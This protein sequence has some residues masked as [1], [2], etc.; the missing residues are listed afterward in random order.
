[1]PGGRTVLR[2]D[3]TRWGRRSPHAGPT[4]SH[5]LPPPPARALPPADAGT[6]VLSAGLLRPGLLLGHRLRREAAG[7]QPVRRAARGPPGPAVA[8]APPLG[9]ERIRRLGR[10]R[11]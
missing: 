8:A 1:P 9:V 7:G 2:A 3:M 5:R 6:P 10:E 4:P 11:R